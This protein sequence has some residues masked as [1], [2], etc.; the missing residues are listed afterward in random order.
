MREKIF[1]GLDLSAIEDNATIATILYKEYAYS[2]ALYSDDEIIKFIKALNPTAVAIDAPFK[3]PK[4]GWFRDCDLLMKK[5]GLR[6]LPPAWRSMRKLTI[7]A[8]KLISK[9][10]KFRVIETFPSGSLQLAGFRGIKNRVLQHKL[11]SRILIHEKLIVVTKFPFSK[12]LLDSLLAVLA[13]KYFVERIDKCVVFRGEE[14]EVVIPKI[15][16]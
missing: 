7:R 9:L 15:L 11:Y 3:L 14:C 10:E 12:D 5:S 16:S 13:A 2:K 6:P 4:F 8:V 1:V